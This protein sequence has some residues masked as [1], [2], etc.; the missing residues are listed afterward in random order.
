[1]PTEL[2]PIVGRFVRM[3]LFGGGAFAASVATHSSTALAA[4]ATAT[5][6]DTS[7]TLE[8]VVVTGSRIATPNLDAVS[9]ITA[10]SAGEI[11]NS[12][13][14]RVE[15]IINSLPQVVSDQGSGLSMGSNGTATI[16][17]RGLGA[18]R[19]LVLINGRRLMGGDPGGAQGATP[20]YA[21]AADVNMV[22]VALIERIDVLS[23]GASSTYGA[24]AV[25]GVVNFVMND[26][27]EGFRL[28]T[29]VSIYNHS[30]HESYWNP[31][32]ESNK[33]TPVSGTNWDA[34][35]Q[36]ITAIM[37]HNF[38]DGMGNI[39]AYLGWNHQ[40]N[41]TANQRDFSAC[42]S[43]ASSPPAPWACSG[44]S[45]SAPAVFYDQT[46]TPLQ[47]GADGTVGPRYQKYNYAAS[48]YLTREDQRWTA[49][50]FGK[51]KFNDHAEAY[52]E[53]QFLNDTTGAFYAPAGAFLGSGPAISPVNGLKDG[54]YT[55]N[56]GVGAY[57]NA[58]MNPYMTASEYASICK[59]T[60]A[61]FLS[62]TGQAQLLLG[63]RNI[64]GGPRE[65]NYGHEAY[66]GV[67]GVR[68]EIVQDWN[69][70]VY[71]LYGTTNASDY[72]AN[73]T[74]SARINNAL[75]AVRSPT[76]QIVCAGTPPPAGCVPWNIF[77]PAIPITPAQV[78]Y[79]SVPGIFNGT[80]TEYIADGFVS[81]DLTRMGVKTPW[82]DSGLKVV[83]G[84][85]YR[86]E[87]LQTF[88]DNEYLTADLAGLGSPTP[89]VNAGYHVW[90]AYTEERLPIIK[91]GVFAK[92]LDFE[93]GYRYSNYTV[94]YSTN[95]YKFG[96]EWEPINDFRLRGS[97]NR[98][99]RAPNIQELYQPQ[100]VGLDSGIDGCA[101][102]TYTQAQCALTGVKAGQ[103]PPAASPAGQYNGRIG[104]SPNLTPETAT[105]RIFGL[106]FT[107]T[108]LPNFSA[109]FD[110]VDIKIKN[111]INSYGSSLIE[112]NCIASGSATSAWCQLIHRD[113][114]GT[115]WSSPQAY[116]IDPLL[117]EGG[118]ENKSYDI[119]MNYKFDMGKFGD[120]RTRMVG[121]YLALFKFTPG[122]LGGVGGIAYNCAGMVGPDCQPATPKWRHV[123]TADWDTPLT[124]FGVGMSWRY[125]GETINSK[126][127]TQVPPDFVPG[128]NPTDPYMA[129]ISYFDVHASYVW[130]KATF[131]LGVNNVFDKDPPLIDTVVTGGN[132]IYA[133][134]NTNPGT[135]D[136]LGRYIFLNVT[137]DF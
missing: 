15:D 22:P 112:S 133:E 21:S 70:D 14:T 54:N 90:E 46:F 48:H 13:V 131:R 26:H 27:F 43:S 116:S 108:F 137:V 74:S 32:L 134:S 72:H 129:A 23:G 75:Q 3:A 33:F 1:M 40:V 52:T 82:A 125:F 51:M 93:T 61:Q 103:Y 20:G 29:N 8:E 84:S 127:S 53:F 110:W 114:G 121:T 87:T 49:G 18:Q 102:Q 85:E 107:P 2:N 73:D 60:G 34:P 44:S 67:L 35:N 57:G 65:D 97:Y 10:I 50:F 63:R 115:L 59:G 25:A 6:S 58:G 124:G 5:A 111:L 106:V 17:L 55:T 113:A 24:D 86:A 37:G 81:G 130:N 94:G 69:Y 68:G 39:E 56:C 101:Y 38:A 105:T 95:T 12:G 71:G 36:N 66:R 11:A 128:Y 89:P 16:D 47:V 77:N 99:V 80:L 62:P 28:D 30:N 109:T 88:P 79:I 42:V 91:D 41:A 4:A 117:N 123:F 83:V 104:G 135:Y 120:V 98:A 19:T 96:L 45:N 126:T 9:P 119:A 64:E 76:G 92:A 118:E 132:Q 100:H 122:A 78:G 31:V 7:T 136:M